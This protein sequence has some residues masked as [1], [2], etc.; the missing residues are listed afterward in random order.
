MNIHE[1]QAKE[2]LRTYGLPVS[3]G[4]AA[5]TPEEAVEIAK[6]LGGPVWVVKAQIHAGGRGKAG[7]VK[8]V[9][10]LEEVRTQAEHMLWHAPYHAS[11]RG[12]GTSCP[13]TVY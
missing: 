12:R 7:G 9:K 3:R 4:K 6:E 8:V 11:N 10:S 5:V 2:L 13:Q 1:H